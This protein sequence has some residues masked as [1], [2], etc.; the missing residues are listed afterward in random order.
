MTGFGMDQVTRYLRLLD[1]RM[2]IIMHSGA[3]WKP[4]YAQELE[5]IDA[6]IAVL[7][8]QM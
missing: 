2:Y 7:R 3:D 8:Q 4:E 6:E 1:R 5:D